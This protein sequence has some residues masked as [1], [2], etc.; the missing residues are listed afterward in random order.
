MPAAREPSPAMPPATI[1][2]GEAAAA[3]WQVVIGGAGPAGAAAALRFARRGLRV[4]LVDRGSMPRW[5]GIGRSMALPH[6][7]P[8]S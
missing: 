2:L 3:P 6:R 8:G 7:I 5:K 1:S 4:L